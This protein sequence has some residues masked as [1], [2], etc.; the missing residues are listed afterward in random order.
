[1]NWF[2]YNNTSSWKYKIFQTLY[3]IFYKIFYKIQYV[4]IQ[5]SFKFSFH[6]IK[7]MKIDIITWIEYSF[8]LHLC[9]SM[10]IDG[11]CTT[12][13]IHYIRYTN[14]LWS[15]APYQTLQNHLNSL[16]ILCR[17]ISGGAASYLTLLNVCLEAVHPSTS[18]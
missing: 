6:I 15:K 16:H 9:Y 14:I 5:R 1:M 18:P 12:T 4:S 7:T 11:L 8:T 13:S 17:L 2:L 10:I 3:H